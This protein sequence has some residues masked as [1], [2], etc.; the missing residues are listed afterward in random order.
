[1]LNQS[2]I[3]LVLSLPNHNANLRCDANPV[4]LSAYDDK[5]ELVSDIIILRKRLRGKNLALALGFGQFVAWSL[6]ALC[7]RVRDQGKISLANFLPCWLHFTDSL[8]HVIVR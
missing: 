6:L 3:G 8:H 5:P 7:V 2:K 1:M 4:T